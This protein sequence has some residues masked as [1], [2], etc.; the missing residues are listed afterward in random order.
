MQNI[1]GIKFDPIRE[2]HVFAAVSLPA[3]DFA[4]FERLRAPFESLL[5]SELV[6]DMSAHINSTYPLY[7]PA[8]LSFS[9]TTLPV[10]DALLS[11]HTACILDNHALASG[12]HVWT[13][14]RWC[15][16]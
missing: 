13:H 16:P 5:L 8:T 2:S 1:P 12:D 10:S 14:L 6:E 11:L 15:R 7:L 3:V 4:A 9:P